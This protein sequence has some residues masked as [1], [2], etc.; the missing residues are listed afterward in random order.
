MNEFCRELLTWIIY[1]SETEL[2]AKGLREAGLIENM[3]IN[4]CDVI[5][6]ISTAP[7]IVY[8]PQVIAVETITA[9]KK[10]Y[11]IKLLDHGP[12]PNPGYDPDFW[13]IW[14]IFSIFFYFIELYDC[15]TVIY[16]YNPSPVMKWPLQ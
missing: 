11:T 8:Y 4:H 15:V 9:R 1:L 2:C 3:S 5:M 7:Q 13:C 10:R 16:R 14:C 6:S 12:Q